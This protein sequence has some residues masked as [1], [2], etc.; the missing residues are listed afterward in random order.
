MHNFS[1]SDAQPLQVECTTFELIEGRMHN[2]CRSD[3]H[4]LQGHMHIFCKKLQKLIQPTK[5]VHLINKSCAS[6]LLKLCI[7]PTKVVHPPYLCCA[8][9][10]L[11]LCIKIPTYKYCASDIKKSA[12]NSRKLCNRPTVVYS[13]SD[14]QQLDA[15]GKPCAGRSEVSQEECNFWRMY[16][17]P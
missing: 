6:N 17:N 8:S 3:A 9:D 14:Q 15:A 10:L 13:I 1:R 4:I 7:Q 11:M 5:G 16:Y 12:T 2:F